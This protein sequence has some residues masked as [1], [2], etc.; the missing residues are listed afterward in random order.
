M[1]AQFIC[2]KL[3][4]VNLELRHKLTKRLI[5]LLIKKKKNQ[6]DQPNLTQLEIEYFKFY[7]VGGF[8]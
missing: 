5:R 3:I 8:Y 6:A 2:Y 4:F 1:Q 7:C